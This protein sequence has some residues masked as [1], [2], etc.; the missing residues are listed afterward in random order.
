MIVTRH[1]GGQQVWGQTGFLTWQQLLSALEPITEVI[2]SGSDM[3]Y[4]VEEGTK[5]EQGPLAVTANSP[6]QL[7]INSA[8]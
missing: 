8:W 4:S 6:V 1:R 3:V 2:Y 5:W 7:L